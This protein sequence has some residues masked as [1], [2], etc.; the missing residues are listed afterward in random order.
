VT[1]AVEVAQVRHRYGARVALDGVSFTVA[2]GE[3]FGVIGPNGSGKS[4]LFSL[5]NSSRKIQEGKIAIGGVEAGADPSEVR[6]RI[7][8][9]FQ[10][11][12]TDKYLTCREN[13]HLHGVL[14]G[15]RPDAVAGR[16]AD[17]LAAAGL[18]DRAGDLVG[19]LSGGLGRRLELAR[20]LLHL[21]AVLLLD[22]PA[23]SLDPAARGELWSRLGEWRRARGLTVLVTTHDMAEA[24]RCDRLAILDAGKI[25]VTGTPSELTGALGGAV[26][27]IRTADVAAISRI[28]QDQFKANPIAV[29]DEVRFAAEGAH[30]LVGALAAACGPAA[31]SI[32]VG[33][34]TLDDVFVARTG[35]RF[36]GAAA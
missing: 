24:V 25:V 27:S 33:A 12:T 28:I 31:T 1:R 30:A 8:I 26:I 34:P 29:G 15:L 3:L 4:T 13:L 10:R 36:D 2:P 35:H 16:V 23:G 9:V 6:R 18:A 7:G 20:A 32:T 21:P 19:S 11:P 22:E 17:A 14:Q 5:L